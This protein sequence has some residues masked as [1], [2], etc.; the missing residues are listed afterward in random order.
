M[1]LSSC[2]VLGTDTGVG[3]TVVTGLITKTLLKGGLRVVPFKPVATGAVLAPAFN[4]HSPSH[5]FEDTVFLSKVSGVSPED[6]SLYQL[7]KP[8]SPHLAAAAESVRIDTSEIKK[9]FLA[10]SRRCQA[11]VVEGVGGALVP[12]NQDE[13]LIDLTVL[14]DIPVVIVARPGLGTLNHTLLT[15]NACEH[16]GLHI[17]GLIINQYPEK[18]DEAERTNPTELE[19]LTGLPILGKVPI[20]RGLSVEK[21]REGE[22]ENHLNS[23]DLAG[24]RPP[25]FNHHRA[26]TADKNYVWHPFTPM[27]EYLAEKPHPLMIVKGKGNYLID[28]EDNHYLDGVSSLWVNVHGH[29]QKELDQAVTS[30]LSKIAHSTMLGLTNEPA[31]LLAEELV[32]IAPGPLTRVFYSD[33]GST[34]VEIGLKVAFQYWQ[35]AGYPKKKEFVS[36]TNAYHGDTIG[37]VSVGGMELFHS[38]FEPLLFKSHL[39]PSAYCYRCPRGLAYPACRFDCLK[40]LEELFEK[41]SSKIAA[42]VLEPKVQAAAGILIQP[43]GYLRK[44]ADLCERHRVLLILDEVATGF[45]RT[46]KMFACQH[47]GIEPDILTLAK[48]I[49][50]GY[51][52]LAATLFKEFI[53]QAFLGRFEE[54]KTFFHGHTYTGNPLACAAS[55]ANLKLFREK[56]VMGSV[57]KK[58]A[59][60]KE[61]LEP[62][63]GI[64]WVG[65]VRQLGFMVGIELVKDKGSKEPFEA[66]ERMGRRVILKARERGVIIRP[67]GDVVVLMP[68]LSISEEELANLVEA[69]KWALVKVGEGC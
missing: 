43:P 13:F 60:L 66:G 53:Y 14:L 68:P 27:L 2:F 41:R 16:R 40:P 26:L 17:A 45:G 32:N 42:V 6:I 10:L 19:N 24:A 33:S 39:M 67:L 18:P 4:G 50:G 38:K 3:K 21:V 7:P 51:L 48:G 55:L 47:E 9:K 46:G 34:A 59:K 1:K 15:V 56:D 44:L 35:Q 12:L 30:Q 54:L 61:L 23:L 57:E 28:N 20:I 29:R 58:A 52:P 5:I 49:T 63:Q 37:A 31:S 25:G 36:F 62:L 8:L 11:V 22:L 65:D 64:E 69:T